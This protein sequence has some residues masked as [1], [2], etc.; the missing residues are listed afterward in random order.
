MNEPLQGKSSQPVPEKNAAAPGRK[1][2]VAQG[3]LMAGIVLL[4]AAAILVLAVRPF[5]SRESRPAPEKP[6]VVVPQP[7]P[8]PAAPVPGPAPVPA[9]PQV[10]VPAPAP[11]P[12]AVPA[13]EPPQAPSPI[14]AETLPPAPVAAEPLPAEAPVDLPRLVTD[15]GPDAAIAEYVAKMEVL[16]YASGQVLLRLPGQEEARGCREGDVLDDAFPLTILKV[17]DRRVTFG[18]D[19]GHTYSRSY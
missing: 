16:G 12:A 4:L 14:A 15:A 6:A 1:S 19:R 10:E 7:V 2:L 3:L 17:T 5:L 18:D 8:Q 11:V 13:P 9:A